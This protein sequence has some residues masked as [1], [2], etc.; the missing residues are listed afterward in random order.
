MV[1]LGQLLVPLGVPLYCLLPVG[2]ILKATQQW[3]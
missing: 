1:L 2:F 3:L